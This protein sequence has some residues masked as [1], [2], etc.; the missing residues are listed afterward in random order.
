MARIKYCDK[1][2]TPH[3]WRYAD[4]VPNTSLPDGTN[5]NDVLLWDATNSEWAPSAIPDQNLVV[6]FTA[7]TS[8]NTT[9]YTPSEYDADIYAAYTSGVQ[10]FFE[11]P[12][13]LTDGLLM[14]ARLI[15]GISVSGG[16][17]FVGQGLLY[18]SGT[19]NGITVVK[20]VTWDFQSF[21]YQTLPVASSGDSGKVLT[22]DS[23]GDWYKGTIDLSSKITA[24]VSPSPGDVLTYD[25]TNGW[26]A[27]SPVSTQTTA[28]S[29]PAEGTLW[30]DTTDNTVDVPNGNSLSY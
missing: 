25:S 21:E 22:V 27:S 24:P 10:V 2:V 17:G 29:S 13:T 26:V 30:V 7:T 23:N 16:Y 12:A 20:D 18:D 3:V 1:S 11:I 8:N 5:P 14:Y 4:I 9:T 15:Y 6:T 19:I 28:P